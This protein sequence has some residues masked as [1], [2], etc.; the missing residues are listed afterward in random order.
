MENIE[1]LDIKTLANA[2]TLRALV[3]IRVGPVIIHDC[4]IIRQENQKPWFALPSREFTGKDGERKFSPAVELP[5]GLKREVAQAVLSSW[6]QQEPEDR[7]LALKPKPE[8]SD[9]W[10]D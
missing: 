6:Q 9:A 4:K 8:R 3:S 1:I 2:G 7:P 10:D 5:E